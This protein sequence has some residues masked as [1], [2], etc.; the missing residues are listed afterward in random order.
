[1]AK[2]KIEDI[3]AII[4]QDN[5]KVISEKYENLDSEMIF[6][7]SEGHRVF[8]PWKKIRQKRECPICKNNLFKNQN[9]KI[10]SKKPGTKRVLALDQA[11]YITG[12]SIY[13]NNKLIKFGTFSTYLDSEIARDNEIKHWLISMIT[14]W[15]PDFVGLEGIQFQQDFGV[16]TFETLARLQG[17]LWETVYELH[18]NCE[19]CHTAVWRNH[20]QVKG[21][22][23]VDKKKSMQ[24]LIKKWFDVSVT[25]DEADAIGIGKYMAEVIVKRKSMENWE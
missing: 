6:E 4:E 3:Q 17:I 12:W 10:I 9:T 24:L 16:S 13:D 15:N 20:C 21:K 1:M 14:S 11:T 2:I 25:E 5:W 18:I 8:A 19:I 7:C 22:S 23:R